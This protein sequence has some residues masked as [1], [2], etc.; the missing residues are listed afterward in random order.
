MHFCKHFQNCKPCTWVRSKISLSWYIWCPDYYSWNY[1]Q[2]FK[3]FSIFNVHV[4]KFAGCIFIEA[5]NVKILSEDSTH[6]FFQLLFKNVWINVSIWATVN[7]PL[8][9][10]NINPSLLSVDCC[11]VRGG[12]GCSCCPTFFPKFLLSNLTCCLSASAAYL[13]VFMVTSLRVIF[14]SFIF[15]LLS[16]SGLNLMSQFNYENTT[17]YTKQTTAELK[18]IVM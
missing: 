4:N 18:V 8:P 14:K 5:T 3:A 9:S 16:T 1:R 2:G 6:D 15:A 7:L 12:V 13:Q 17:T 10:P 11:W